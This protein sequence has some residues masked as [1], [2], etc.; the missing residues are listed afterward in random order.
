MSMVAF[1]LIFEAGYLTEPSAHRRVRL[2]GQRT[3]EIL[4]S[5]PPSSGMTSV[6]HCARLFMWVPAI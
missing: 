4:L 2:V 3:P 6:C 1:H 5:L